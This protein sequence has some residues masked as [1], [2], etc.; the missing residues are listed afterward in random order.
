MAEMTNDTTTPGDLDAP[1]GD[2]E[3]TP[4]GA[5]LMDGNRLR[6]ETVA[7]LRI[8]IDELGK[9]DVCLATVLVG[10][11]KPSQI[12]VRM[13]QRKAEEAGMVPRHVELPGSASQAEV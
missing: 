3:R 8:E 9:P 10:G 4:A 11:D 13:K 6:D 2:F 1:T 7:R 12:Y 5:V